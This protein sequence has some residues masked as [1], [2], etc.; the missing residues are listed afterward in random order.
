MNFT[1]G[2][3]LALTIGCLLLLFSGCNQSGSKKSLKSLK[4]N[5]EAYL[6]VST[7]S[8]GDITIV[9]N[10][11]LW[12]GSIGKMIREKMDVFYDGW[13]SR[14]K[15][16]NI[17]QVD[18]LNLGA[19]LKKDGCIIVFEADRTIDST[20]FIIKDNLWAKP[21]RLFSFKAPNKKTLKAM[22][23]SY[24]DQVERQIIDFEAKR[25]RVHNLKNKN[26]AATQILKKPVW[27]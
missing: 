8:W 7:G 24:Y 20:S 27:N 10:N 21:Q 9:I 18:Q 22:F 6:P 26:K 11:G 15:K 5:H 3:A 23:I 19:L 4:K 14:E 2:N 16:Y 13:P 17:V 12:N 25:S 1:K